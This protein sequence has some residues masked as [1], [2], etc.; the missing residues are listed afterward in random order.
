MT[1]TGTCSNR[2]PA[3]YNYCVWL[4]FK[5]FPNGCFLFCAVLA[6]NKLYIHKVD[7]L[8]NI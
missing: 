3:S 4:L 1:Q 6:T 2:M 7:V 8:F 5:L